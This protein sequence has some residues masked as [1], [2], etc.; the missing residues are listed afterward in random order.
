[1]ECPVV[2]LQNLDTI[3]CLITALDSLYEGYFFFNLRYVRKLLSVPWKN[4]VCKHLALDSVITLRIV[5]VNA[6]LIWLPHMT[7]PPSAKFDLL[8]Y[9]SKL[10]ATKYDRRIYMEK[11]SVEKDLP[12][13]STIF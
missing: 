7:L 5:D 8:F 2:N 6:V 3:Y 9:F 11:T 10:K 1:M 13:L 4:G 12:M